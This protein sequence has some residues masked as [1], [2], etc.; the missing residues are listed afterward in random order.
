MEDKL[1]FRL[2]DIDINTTEKTCLL[3]V[4]F[5]NESKFDD[6]LSNIFRKVSAQK[7]ALNRFKNILPRKTKRN[8]FIAHL[9]CCIWHHCGKRDT[10]IEK[11]NKRTLRYIFKDKSASQDLLERIR[12]PS[13]ETQRIQDNKQ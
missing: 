5:D 11:V 8:H 4:V 7:S 6:H 9:Y 13:M 12:L 3:E 1:N 2:A 10:K